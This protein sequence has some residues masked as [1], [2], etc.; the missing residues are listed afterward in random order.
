MFRHISAPP[1]HIVCSWQRL[2]ML[3]FCLGIQQLGLSSEICNTWNQ[4]IL[5]PVGTC[6]HILFEKPHCPKQHGKL[7][8]TTSAEAALL[9]VGY[10]KFMLR[11]KGERTDSGWLWTR[12]S[13]Y[14]LSAPHKVTIF[15]SSWRSL[16]VPWLWAITDAGISRKSLERGAVCAADSWM[17]AGRKKCQRLL[18]AIYFCPDWVASPFQDFY[19]G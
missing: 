18:Q 17:E 14:L 7:E 13:C 5:L 9:H 8:S 11:K 19:R 12:R 3:C 15:S 16:S 6:M 4:T 10:L 2:T 1:D